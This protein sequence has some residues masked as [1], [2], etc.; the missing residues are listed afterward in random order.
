MSAS[1]LDLDD[2]GGKLAAPVADN[3]TLAN[4]LN[5]LTSSDPPRSAP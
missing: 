1:A 5:R 2:L 3:K 4:L